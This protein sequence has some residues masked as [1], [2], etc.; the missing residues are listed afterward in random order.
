MAT[1][2]DTVHLVF[3]GGG[4]RLPYRRSVDGGLCWD[5]IRDLI[6]DTTT[7]PFIVGHSFPV[8]NG[9]RLLVFFTGGIDGTGESPIYMMCSTDRGNTWSVPTAITVPDAWI[10]NV[11]VLGDTIAIVGY[12]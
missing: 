7:F 8:T 5:P 12:V 3:V 1:Q 6:I 4:F 2:G 10:Q 11:A 9:S